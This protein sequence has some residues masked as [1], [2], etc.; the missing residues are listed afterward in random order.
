MLG[1]DLGRHGPP[2]ADRTPLAHTAPHI[3][4]QLRAFCTWIC[5]AATIPM[6][7]HLTGGV[8]SKTLSTPE[9]ARAGYQFPWSVTKTDT[10]KS[11]IVT[12]ASHF[13]S[14]HLYKLEG[15]THTGCERPVHFNVL[16]TASHSISRNCSYRNMVL[17]NIDHGCHAAY[18][19][20]YSLTRCQAQSCKAR[21]LVSGQGSATGLWRGWRI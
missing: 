13:F 11:S 21:T 6:M 17:R 14:V 12:N 7:P 18:I 19:A 3:F 10:W 1:R 9:Q 2:A 5:V 20:S 8:T 16:I 15:L 4:H